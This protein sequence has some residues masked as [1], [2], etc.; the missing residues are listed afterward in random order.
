MGMSHPFAAQVSRD[1]DAAEKHLE[2]KTLFESKHEAAFERREMETLDRVVKAASLGSA[3]VATAARRREARDLGAASDKDAAFEAKLLSAEARRETELEHVA[4]KARALGSD[5]VAAA[6]AEQQW[7]VAAKKADEDFVVY[8]QELAEARKSIELQKKVDVAHNMG[9]RKVDDAAGRRAA[10][11]AA[12]KESLETRLEAAARRK[13]EGVDYKA[14]KPTA[15]R[16]PPATAPPVQEEANAAAPPSPTPDVAYRGDE[17]AARA[18]LL[19][20]AS[21]FELAGVAV[22]AVTVLAALYFR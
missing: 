21:A 12:K 17:P 2:R 15:K 13:T 5:K 8:Q 14:P 7:A 4:A 9:Q 3:A 10:S 22:A 1:V 11:T 16:A 18:S 6:A 19:D 20:N